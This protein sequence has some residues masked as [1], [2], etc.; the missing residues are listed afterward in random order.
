MNDAVTTLE[1]LQSV[2]PYFDKIVSVNQ[3][4]C[5]INREK[6]GTKETAEKFTYCRNLMDAERIEKLLR[7]AGSCQMDGRNYIRIVT[8]IRDN[9]VMSATLIPFS[10]MEKE[11]VKFV[12]MGRCMPEKNHRSIIL[13]MKRLIEERIS[14]C[15]YIIGDG[16]MR[17]ELEGLSKELGIENRIMITGFVPNPFAI[18]KECDCFVFPSSYEAQPFAVLEART[19]GLPIVVS[20]YPAVE[21]VM[22]EDKQY[23]MEGTDED[24][25]YQGM[26]AYL[27]GKVPSDYHFDVEEYNNSAY[28]EFLVILDENID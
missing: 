22:L 9:G 5:E 12:T 19:V 24:A 4:I 3:L 26:R 27:D 20:N 8:E 2:Y 13:A 17:E 18:L 7:S 23:I 6:L 15:L 25:V 11:C 16:H 28:R 1:G 10:H 21:S 14:C